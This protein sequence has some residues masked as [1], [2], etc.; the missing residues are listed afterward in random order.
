MKRKFKY[1]MNRSSEDW[2]FRKRRNTPDWQPDKEWLKTWYTGVM[3]SRSRET[4]QHKKLYN[5]DGILN[6]SANNNNLRKVMSPT[7][8]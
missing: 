5:E 7:L 2:M 6:Q 3:R 1:I 8:Q 4:F